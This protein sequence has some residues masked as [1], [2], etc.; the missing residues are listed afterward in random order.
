MGR[1][2]PM[3]TKTIGYVGSYICSGDLDK[4]NAYIGYFLSYNE[5]SL[6]VQNGN[7]LI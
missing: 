6:Y 3:I 2:G 1:F 7:F 4:R 5:H